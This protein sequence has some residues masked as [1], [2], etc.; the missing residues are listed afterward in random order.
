MRH[1]ILSLFLLLTTCSIATAQTLQTVV[2]NGNT[3]T[4][5]V[6]FNGRA[7]FGESYDAGPYGA[8]QITRA[9]NQGAKF[10]LSFIRNGQMVYG[11]GFLNNSSV[12]GIQPGAD[13][14]SSN[15]IFMLTDG[16]VGV[17]TEAPT[18]KLTVSENS[19]VNSYLTVKNSVIT[20]V[21]GAGG[22]SLGLIG[23][24]SNHTLGFYTNNTEKMRIMPDGT[25]GIGTQDPKG[26][27]LAVGGNMIAESVKVKLKGT[28]PDFVF[29]KEYVLPTL[30]ET[31]KHIKE[32][33]HLP[34]IPTA[35]E[36]EKNGIELGDMN[37]KL[38]QKI[39]ELTLYLI[40]MNK[41]VEDQSAELAK[42][43]EQINQLKK[44]IQ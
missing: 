43:K 18:S 35:A 5:P 41:T 16:K 20:T 32:N 33:G 12:F 31:E 19:G 39:E 44:T 42:Q 4:T 6:R 15:G 38:L 11:M 36:V 21:F 17:G 23:T 29:A 30:Q 40:K 26:Y 3:V 28:W 27:M 7:D 8:V 10:H 14:S 24:Q 13:N 25:V 1:Q 34:G 9:E 22:S 2:T 37:K